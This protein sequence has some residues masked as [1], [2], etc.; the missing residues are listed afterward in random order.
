MFKPYVNL[1]HAIVPW[2]ATHIFHVT[3]RAATYVQ[4]G[5]GDTTLRYIQNL[6]FTVLALAAGPQ[7]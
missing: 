5:S 4:T 7:R 1:W 2:V 3:G 6:L